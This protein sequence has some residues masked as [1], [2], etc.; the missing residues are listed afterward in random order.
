MINKRQAFYNKSFILVDTT[1]SSLLPSKY[2]P[3]LAT[4]RF[5]PF[6]KLWNAFWNASFGMANN[7]F[8]ENFSI[9]SIVSNRRPFKVDF[10]I[11]NRKKSA[12]AKSGE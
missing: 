7:S 2:T 5:Q 6:C 3:S 4:H 9:S 1:Y 12:G 10:N 8:V 11:E